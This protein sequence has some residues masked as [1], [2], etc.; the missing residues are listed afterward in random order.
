MGLKGNGVRIIVHEPKDWSKGNLF[1]VIILHREDRLLVQLSKQIEGKN[2][3][4]D[5]LEL[6]PKEANAT[7]RLLEKYYS[8]FFN[9]ML[10]HD[11]QSE[12]VISGSVTID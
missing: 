5:L 8:V 11:N 3:S 1:G 12:F 9:G 6:H 2:F 4:S 10:I 7:F